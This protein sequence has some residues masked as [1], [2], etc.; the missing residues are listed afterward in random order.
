MLVQDQTAT[1]PKTDQEQEVDD[2]PAARSTSRSTAA[3][4]QALPQLGAEGIPPPDPVREVG[5]LAAPISSNRRLRPAICLREAGFGSRRPGFYSAGLAS[6]SGLLELRTL[7]DCP[8]NAPVTPR[9]SRPTST[10]RCFRSARTRRLTR[11]SRPTA[12]A[13]RRCWARR[14][15]W[16][17]A[18]RCGRCRRRRSSTSTTT[19]GRGICSS[20]AT[21]STT[22]K[23][24]TTT[25]SSP[26]IS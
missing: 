3:P 21:S 17:R 19:C 7:P 9:K 25:S 4:C 18:R 22:R 13:P 5:R 14:C 11:R 24:P 23:P 26:S 16:C 15:W 6:K 8:M 10:R 20:C 12:C 2:A 1:Q